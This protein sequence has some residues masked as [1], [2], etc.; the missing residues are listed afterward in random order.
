MPYMAA[1]SQGVTT[2]IRVDKIKIAIQMNA[3][4]PGRGSFRSLGLSN[5]FK[6]LRG[7]TV[8]WVMLDT[9]M[10]SEVLETAIV[11]LPF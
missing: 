6:P 5:L 2:P 3:V 4:L 1:N 8:C 9:G 10:L 7:L 11:I